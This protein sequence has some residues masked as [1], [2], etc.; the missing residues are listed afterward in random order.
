MRDFSIL[1]ITHRCIFLFFS[2][3]RHIIF[4]MSL[5]PSPEQFR[6]MIFYDCKIGLTCKDCHARLVQAWGGEQRTFPPHTL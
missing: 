6:I 1:R 2:H 3:H 5:Q 4:N